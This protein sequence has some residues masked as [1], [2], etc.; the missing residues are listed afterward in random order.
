MLPAL[1]AGQTWSIQ[2]ALLKQ[3]ADSRS[4]ERLGVTIAC[5]FAKS[6]TS[7]MGVLFEGTHPLGHKGAPQ[8][9]AGTRL[10]VP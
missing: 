2:V 10:E 8:S 9:P 7:K 6:A 5:V 3:R 4:C 1:C